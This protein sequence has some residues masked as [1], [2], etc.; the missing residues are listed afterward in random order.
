M[1]VKIV[2]VERVEGV[3]T[4]AK[5]LIG[6][7]ELHFIRLPETGE[8]F[9]EIRKK[10]GSQVLDR[11]GSHIPDAEY[12]DLKKKIEKIFSEKRP[13]KR[14]RKNGIQDGVQGRLIP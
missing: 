6:N 3:V 5:A 14:I 1:T 2:H 12:Q 13:V 10:Q 8:P 11:E 9:E 7:I 4:R